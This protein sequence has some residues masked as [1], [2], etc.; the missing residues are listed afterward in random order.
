MQLKVAMVGPFHPEPAI[1]G[2]EQH[3]HHLSKALEKEGV[4]V[5]R[6]S[7]KVPR[8]GSGKIRG[9]SLL[10]LGKVFA[11]TDADLVHLHSSAIAFSLPCG[12]GKYE[13]RAIATIHAF[14]EPMLEEGLRMKAMGFALGPMYEAA[15][16]K[17]RNIAVSN[18]TKKEAEGRGI[19]VGAIIG[20]GISM[21]EIR[22][23][24]ESR[25]LESDIL[26]VARLNKQKGVFDFIEAFSGIAYK[27]LIMGY[28]EKGAEER[29]KALASE[30]WIKFR[31]RPS[32]EETLRAMKSTKVL[33]FPSRK[34]SFGI[35]G[36]EAMAFGKPVIVYDEAGG[37]L[38][39][40]REGYNGRVVSSRPDAL[41]IGAA[42]MIE[43]EKLMGKMRA[44]CIETAKAH[45]W[46][47]VAK[48]V[49][50]Y[51][52]SVIEQRGPALFYRKR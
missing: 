40:V 39:Y 20:S 25:E 36:L 52:E 2:V 28:G 16:R 33:A 48:E 50:A 49:K 11:E 27:C 44:N 4:E 51:Y 3:V 24:E 19:R 1:G 6:W 21:E 47:K 32:R 8:S 29:V 10:S 26:L 5:E 38:D 18:Y 45:S 37:P 41:R 43:D 12:L 7:W 15:L 9:C 22:G 17:T 30:K 42:D 13:G 14:Y 23:V 46:E 35:V 34:E 31:I